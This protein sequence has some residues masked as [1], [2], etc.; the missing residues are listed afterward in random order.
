MDQEE[1]LQHAHKLTDSAGLY[2]EELFSL[3]C[4]YEKIAIFIKL[5][6]LIME[7]DIAGDQMAVEMLSWTYDQLANY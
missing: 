6:D 3:G 5:R 1:I 4:Q 2:G 7:K